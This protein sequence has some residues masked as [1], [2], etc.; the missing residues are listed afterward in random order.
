[1]PN[2][3][4]PTT[5]VALAAL[6][7][8]TLAAPPMAWATD[9]GTIPSYGG[10]LLQMGL[11]LALVCV[12]AV[13]ALKFGLPRWAGARKAPEARLELLATLPVGHK[14]QVLLLRAMDRVIVVGASEG[15]MQLLTDLGEPDGSERSFAE[16]VEAE[17]HHAR[18]GQD[19]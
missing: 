6:L 12:L 2:P 10:T 3:A 19:G 5:L 18:E 16:A 11:S 1:M 15:G 17:R 14:R 13:V 4:P 7:L 9:P 8:V